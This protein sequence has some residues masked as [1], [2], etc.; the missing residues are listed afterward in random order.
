MIGKC[1]KIKQ[2]GGNPTFSMTLPPMLALLLLDASK[3]TPP[4]NEREKILSS[5]NFRSAE[6]DSL[7]QQWYKYRDWLMSKKEG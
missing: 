3:Q 4:E 6:I 2:P 5:V 1:A 7:I